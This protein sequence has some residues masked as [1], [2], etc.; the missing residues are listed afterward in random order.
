M[1]LRTLDDEELIC[2]LRDSA[3]PVVVELL[4][5]FEETLNELEEQRRSNDE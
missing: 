1:N 4:R 2:A 5:R 3:D